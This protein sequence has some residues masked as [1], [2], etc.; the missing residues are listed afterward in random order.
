[1]LKPFVVEAPVCRGVCRAVGQFMVSIRNFTTSEHG[2]A[3]APVFA[4]CFATSS[5]LH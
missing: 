1:M 5:E 3:F 2:C 4:A